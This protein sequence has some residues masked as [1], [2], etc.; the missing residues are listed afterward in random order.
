MFHLKGLKWFDTLTWNINVHR[1]NSVT[2]SDHWVGIVIVSSTISTTRNSKNN[3]NKK[4]SHH[5]LEK[6]YHWLWKPSL[7]YHSDK[8][9]SLPQWLWSKNASIWMYIT[10]QNYMKVYFTSPFICISAE[11][12]AIL[13]DALGVKW[14][15]VCKWG[16]KCVKDCFYPRDKKMSIFISHTKV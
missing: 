12:L 4:D 9:H 8:R 6:F 15:S 13:D 1:D 7:K 16:R 11:T 3:N 10:L 14:S 2:A 5:I